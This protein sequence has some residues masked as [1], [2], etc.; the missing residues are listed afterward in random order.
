MAS[1]ALKHRLP[2]SIYFFTASRFALSHVKWRDGAGFLVGDGD[3]T[4]LMLITHDILLQG[5]EQTLGMLR[6]KDNATLHH[7]LGETGEHTGK[8]NDEVATGMGD[9]GKI[10]I[11][12]LGHIGGQIQLECP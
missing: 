11:V 2:P 9:N 3:G 5:K 12:S 10:G 1:C 6:S 8:I 4:K 7:G